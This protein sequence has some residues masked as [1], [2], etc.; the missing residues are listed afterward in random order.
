MSKNT[1]L[2]TEEINK[3]IK[4]ISD[5]LINECISE[6]FS[7]DEPLKAD[8]LEI[9]IVSLNENYQ[10]KGQKTDEVEQI[11]LEVMHYLA[12]KLSRKNKQY[13]KLFT[14]IFLNTDSENGDDSAY[15]ILS[16]RIDSKVMNLYIA[17]V[18]K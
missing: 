16:S 15:D 18:E 5:K 13:Q 1:I 14:Q 4:D 2:S 17:A 12:D 11:G 7:D 8:D 9:K 10:K 3:L 6:Y